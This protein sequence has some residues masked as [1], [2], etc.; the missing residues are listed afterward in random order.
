MQGRVKSHRL[1]V[2]V[3]AVLAVVALL[4]G[5]RADVLPTAHRQVL[6]EQYQD[7]YAQVADDDP[8]YDA[9]EAYLADD[10]ELAHL[11]SACERATAAFSASHMHTAAATAARNLTVLALGEQAGLLRDVRVQGR[12]GEV[13]LELALAA[14][15]EDPAQLSAAA[16]AVARA[17]GEALLVLAGQG[18]AARACLD[19]ACDSLP[20]PPGSVLTQGLGAA[21]EALYV[22]GLGADARSPHAEHAAALE[23]ARRLAAGE[24]R[25]DARSLAEALQSPGVAGS[26]FYRLLNEAPTG[27]PQRF[28]LWFANY[29]P[30]DEALAKIVL[31]AYRVGR[32]AT[33]V[34]FLETYGATFPG[35]RAL[36]L[37]LLAGVTSPTEVR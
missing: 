9:L 18:Y 1:T 20:A 22:E 23:R 4:T 8:R 10:V 12:Y 25:R 30:Q 34:E 31:V 26:V 7:G 27:Y 16:P 17:V 28:M 36:A 15:V 11:L 13:R 2:R 32:Q 5:C 21:L 37:E 33:I 14:P 35:E 24:Y 6:V 29:D 19:L 3:A